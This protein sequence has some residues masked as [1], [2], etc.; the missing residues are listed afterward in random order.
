MTIAI[1]TT[2][3]RA[4]IF[5]LVA[6]AMLLFGAAPALAYSY[7]TSGWTSANGRTTVAGC[8]VYV[9]HDNSGNYHATV[10]ASETSSCSGSVRANAYYSY[11]PL[12]DFNDSVYKT[13]D[14]GAYK[15]SI[16][17]LTVGSYTSPANVIRHSTTRRY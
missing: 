15:S 17:T 14:Y 5:A 1:S 12:Y 16:S 6:A 4:G 7:T 13:Y 11:S 10:T 8:S 9:S 2:R 3:A